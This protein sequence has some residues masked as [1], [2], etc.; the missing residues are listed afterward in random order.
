MD[1]RKRV[2][3]VGKDDL[4]SWQQYGANGNTTQ[5]DSIWLLNLLT[6]GPRSQFPHVKM[7]LDE[8]TSKAAIQPENSFHF[9]SRIKV[10]VVFSPV[11]PCLKAVDSPDC[12]APY[13]QLFVFSETSDIFTSFQWLPIFLYVF[14]RNKGI[15]AKGL[16]M[17]ANQALKAMG[18]GR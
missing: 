15:G 10:L 2:K 12:G 5:E 9:R 14:R 4:V 13:C 18:P 8:T 3:R 6:V 16:Q 11:S 7:E 1:T 17:E